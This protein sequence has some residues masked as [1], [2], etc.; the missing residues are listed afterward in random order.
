[1]R[2]TIEGSHGTSIS[3][4]QDIK[5]QG[6]NLGSGRAGK[7]VYFWLDK[8]FHF[9]LAIGWYKYHKSIGWFKEDNNP[10]CAIIIAEIQ[11]DESEIL[12]FE[13]STIK[14][15]LLKLAQKRKIDYFNKGQLAKLYNLFISRLEA[16]LR[17]KFKVIIVEVAAPP[18]DFCRN[19][20]ITII[21]VPLSCVARST[22]CIKIKD[23]KICEELE[24]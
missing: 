23:I 16:D 19:Y 24:Q 14:K 4:A 20:P 2:I 1:M 3:K 13:K 12:D 17:V 8:E 15:Q 18:K 9:E 5:K 22:E 10:A 7:G 6:F 11:A 21:G